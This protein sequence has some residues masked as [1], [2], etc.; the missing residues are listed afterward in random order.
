MNKPLDLSGINCED[1]AK[2]KE[3]IWPTSLT[4][5]VNEVSLNNMT[6][7]Q[8]QP[9]SQTVV[10]VERD[11]LDLR[12]MS[13]RFE[14]LKPNLDLKQA[15][16]DACTEFVKTSEQGRTLYSYNCGCFN[17]AD[18]ASSG[19]PEEICVKHGFRILDDDAADLV[20]DW[21]EHLVNDDEIADESEEE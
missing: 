16:Y 14:L 10:A 13:I 18:L 12:V 5:H 21:D 7:T 3:K 15:V 6:C 2:D 17:W 4:Q 11:G 19:I 1:L 8:F 20:V 9:V